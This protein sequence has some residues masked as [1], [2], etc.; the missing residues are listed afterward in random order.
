MLKLKKVSLALMAMLMVV[1]L[2][3][4]DGNS[5]NDSGNGGEQTAP[6]VPDNGY[7]NGGIVNGNGDDSNLAPVMLDGV[8]VPNSRLERVGDDIFPNHAELTTVMAMF[9]IWVDWDVDTGEVSLQSM[10]REEIEFVVGDDVFYL[11]G[12]AITWETETPL[13][14][15]IDGE[16]FVQG[17][18][19][20]DVF[21]A[22]SAF[23]EGGHLH[24]D[25]YGADDMM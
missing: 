20:R 6:T 9:G 17:R 25:T 23:S 19:F 21:G 4:C 12:E 24:I 22:G 18:F 8:G 10:T 15:V 1:M 14:V 16:L 7:E 3:A 11:D 2:F 5:G 13:S